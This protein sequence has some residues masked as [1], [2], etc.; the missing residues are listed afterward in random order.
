MAAYDY[1]AEW[2][3]FLNDDCDYPKWS[4]YFIEGLRS[5]SAGPRGLELGC[6]SGAFCRILTKNGYTM[7][8]TDRSAAMLNKAMR[9]AREEGLDIPFFQADARTFRVPSKFDFIL[10]PN[11]C[12]NY[13]AG[14]ELPGAFRHVSDALKKGGIF[15]FDIS[16]EC[17]LKQ[18]VADTGSVDDRDEVTYLSFGRLDGDTVISDVSLFVKEADGRY[19]RY[20]ETHVQ[21]IH[22]EEQI[23]AALSDAGFTVLCTEGHL[24]TP[25][26]G[27]D[28][29]DFICRKV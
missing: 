23:L 6:G 7:S 11:D 19:R 17:K 2:F 15:W 9:L 14:R 5:L 13:L 18:K 10:S 3:E 25:K 28:R 22:T 8:G 21:Y 12:F 26:E 1:L 4:Q 24:H 27:C 16:S 20:D 29:L